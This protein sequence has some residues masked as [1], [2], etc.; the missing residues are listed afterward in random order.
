MSARLAEPGLAIQEWV[1]ATLSASPALA[2]A[3]GVPQEAVADRLWDSTPPAGSPMPYVEMVVAE[4]R[5]QGGILMA[6]VMATAE[7]TVKAVDEAEGYAT[8]RPVAAACYLALQAQVSVPLNGGGSVLS[9]RR[10]R[11]VQYPELSQGVE[12]RHL[13]ATY[14]V[15]VQ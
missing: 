2:E 3:L 15:T 14:E 11:S 8:V 9:S 1:T 13:G 4:P 12:Y 10:L 6:P 5:D 7:V